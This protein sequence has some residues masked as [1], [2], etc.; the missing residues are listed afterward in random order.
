MGG[1][2]CRLVDEHQ[3]YCPMASQSIAVV[4]RS[5]TKR[6][7]GDYKQGGPMGQLLHGEKA[8]TTQVQVIVEFWYAQRQ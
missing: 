4:N 7:M 3:T 1:A 8:A 5:V 6:K 2:S